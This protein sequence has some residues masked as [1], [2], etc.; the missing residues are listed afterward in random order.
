M[1]LIKSTMMKPV[2]AM[3]TFVITLLSCAQASN[4]DNKTTMDNNNTI[5][6]S[7]QDNDPAAAARYDTATFANG[8]FWCTEAIFEQLDG[9]ISAESGY[10]GGQIANPT[11]Q[12]VC[13]G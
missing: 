11:Y 2:L 10:T 3:T 9:V 4:T 7:K 12:E 13:S 1:L 5:P 6:A 8:C